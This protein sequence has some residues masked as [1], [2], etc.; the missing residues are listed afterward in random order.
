MSDYPRWRFADLMNHV[1]YTLL[2]VL[3]KD[4]DN[5]FDYS[6]CIDYAKQ[7]FDEALSIIRNETDETDS[8]NI[9]LAEAQI[10][11][12]LG[13]YCLAK[14]KATKNKDFIYDALE[15]HQK[16]LETRQLVFGKAP[17]S[18]EGCGYIGT[19]YNCLATDYFALGE[20]EKAL[21]NHRRAIE[22]R[23]NGNAKDIR[24]VESY[25]R[26]IGT[27]LRLFSATKDIIHIEEALN[28][29]IKLLMLDTGNSQML[30]SLNCLLGN[31]T[32]LINAKNNYEYLIGCIN[33][34]SFVVD[35]DK[36]TILRES[37]AKIDSL[38]NEVSLESNLL[39]QIDR[40][41]S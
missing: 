2:S 19:S 5:G 11:G 39:E 35:F 28:L 14:H 33:E 26:C 12:N 40:F 6:E 22:Y 7:H 23:E 25:N 15:Y 8:A 30:T 10:Y 27:L 34:S 31:R 16:G 32:E 9:K 1:A 18:G 3:A 20:Y 4:M 29:F 41:R 21:E 17:D 37:A 24:K 36:A 13:A 38:C